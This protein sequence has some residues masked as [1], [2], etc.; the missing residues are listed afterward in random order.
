M[1]NNGPKKSHDV[2]RSALKDYALASRPVFSEDLHAKILGAIQEK[3]HEKTTVAPRHA[4]RHAA[5]SGWLAVAAASL[6]VGGV[7]LT[8]YVA[9][10]RIPSAQP[11]IVPPHPDVATA[12]TDEPEM[13]LDEL[14][15]LA[16]DA[17][18]DLNVLVRSRLTEGQWAYLDHDARLAAEALLDQLPFDLALWD[19]ASGNAASEKEM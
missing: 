16:N 5:V 7:L 10:N 2:L 11:G 19:A 13:D 6:L 9:S 4:T 14:A 12:Q 8:W 15:G 17:A 18:K 3:T 1:T